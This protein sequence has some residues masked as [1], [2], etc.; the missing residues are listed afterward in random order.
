MPSKSLAELEALVGE[1]KHTVDDLVVEAGK[2]EEFARAIDD[3][4]PAYRD[5][6]AA[7][8][9]GSDAVL[10]PLTFTRTAFFPRYRPP[11]MLGD[12][13]EFSASWDF[14]IGFDLQYTMHA[15]QDYEFERRVRVGDRLNGYTTLVDVSQHEND[16]RRL[17]FVTFETE[18]RDAD[19]DLVLTE[20]PTNVE[21]LPL[22]EVDAD[23]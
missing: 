9:A 21:V 7:D 3:D 4:D 13:N 8:A 15:S 6:A 10:A 11:G 14:D 23:A 5:E 17:T 22:A 1:T 18:Y 2:V 19:D 12:V 16:E 20:R